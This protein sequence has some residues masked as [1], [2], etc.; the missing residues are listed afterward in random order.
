M[1]KKGGRE[2]LFGHVRAR[3]LCTSPLI[4]CGIQEVNK[5]FSRD[6]VCLKI[7]ARIAP[8]GPIGSIINS[9]I[10]ARRHT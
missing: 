8:K 9:P 1:R 5:K 2:P 7:D 4:L 10:V 3:G 6:Y